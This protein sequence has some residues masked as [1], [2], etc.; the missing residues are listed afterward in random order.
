[1]KKV[2]TTKSKIQRK[3][4]KLR[5]VFLLDVGQGESNWRRR[6]ITHAATSWRRRRRRF[7]V[8][9]K[10]KKKHT[11]TLFDLAIFFF[12][13]CCFVACLS[14]L[15]SFNIFNPFFS[16]LFDYFL[17][18]KI[19]NRIAAASSEMMAVV[20]RRVVVLGVEGH[21]IGRRPMH[22]GRRCCCTAVHHVAHAGAIGTVGSTRA[23]WI[24]S[25]CVDKKKKTKTSVYM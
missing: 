20:L 13:Q 10:F 1:M 23:S 7:F 8:E 22:H 24:Q 5:R 4:N 19:S 3:L 17:P 16:F 9:G 12:N 15:Y 11:H 25:H 2:G 6:N 21:G 14:F 18:I